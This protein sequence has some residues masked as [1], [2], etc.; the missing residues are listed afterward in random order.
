MRN[1]SISILCLDSSPIDLFDAKVYRFE[2]DPCTFG[3]ADTCPDAESFNQFGPAGLLNLTSVYEGLNLFLS[4]PHFLG[5]DETL[6]S[7]VYGLNPDTNLHQTYY[8]IEPISGSTFESFVR[9]QSNFYISPISFTR[10]GISEVWFED[11][12][13]VYLP[14]MWSETHYKNSEELS[15]SIASAI[16][17][18]KASVSKNRKLFIGFG[19]ALVTVGV[20]VFVR[21]VQKLDE[22]RE[23]GERSG[24]VKESESRVLG[25]LGKVKPGDP[26]RPSYG[27]L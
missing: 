10:S 22:W 14:L 13:P 20:F 15:L 17:K 6:T 12:S 21:N 24:S 8:L 23:T 11:L 5:A 7:S 19:V 1:R 4:K 27:T 18:M 26:S 9:I 2:Q 16:S 25:I 3:T